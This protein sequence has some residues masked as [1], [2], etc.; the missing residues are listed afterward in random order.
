[1]PSYEAPVEALFGL[2]STPFEAVPF[3][4]ACERF[5]TYDAS[6]SDADLWYF[7]VGRPRLIVG[8]GDRGTVGFAVLS[9]CWWET[10]LPAQ[11]PDQTSWEAERAEFDRLYTQE[12]ARAI[13]VLGPPKL[14]GQDKDADAHQWSIWRG[15]TGLLVLQQSAYDPQFG[16]DVNYWLH[17]WRGGDPRP[18]SPFIDWLFVVKGAERAEPAVAPDRGGTKHNRGPRSPRRGR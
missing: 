10:I 16:L 12:L 5:S 8:R 6:S 1:V 15:Q 14:A 7:S 9:I 13:A 17:P 4:A 2:A 18:G 11:H 3:R